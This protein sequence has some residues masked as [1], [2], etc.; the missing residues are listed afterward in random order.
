M[1]DYNSP[2]ENKKIP[3]Q[4]CVARNLPNLHINPLW[5]AA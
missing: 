1:I 4:N 5:K 2:I 3:A